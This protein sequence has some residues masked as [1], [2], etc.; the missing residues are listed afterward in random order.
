MGFSENW[1]WKEGWCEH[2]P[3]VAWLVVQLSSNSSQIPKYSLQLSGSCVQIP[4]E[5]TISAL[6]F[7][8]SSS[9]GRFSLDLG[10]VVRN[11]PSAALRRCF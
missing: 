11:F 8:A 4:V 10:V 2:D 6:F 1:T 3:G 7:S 9:H 5:K